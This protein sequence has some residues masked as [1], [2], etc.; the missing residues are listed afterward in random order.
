MYRY[1]CVDG[2][3]L[4]VNF[5]EDNKEIKVKIWSNHVSKFFSVSHL[6]ELMPILRDLY[7]KYPK[8]FFPHDRWNQEENKRYTAFYVIDKKGCEILCNNINAKLSIK[9]RFLRILNKLV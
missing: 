2:L 7:L 3:N 1:V 8:N 9:K 5:M 4:H 6:N